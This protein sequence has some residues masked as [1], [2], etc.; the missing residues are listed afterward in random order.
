L[1]NEV[2]PPIPAATVVLVRDIGDH[3]E[4]LML[5][6][7]AEVS[8]G[9]LW[10]FPGGRV[11]VD[12]GDGERG[13]RHAA[14]REAAEEAGLVVDS[15]VLVPFAHWTPPPVALKRF[16]TWFFVAPAPAGVVSID[17]GEIH[18]HVWVTPSTAFERHAGGEIQLAPPTWVTLHWLAESPN[19]D[20]AMQRARAETVEHFSTHIAKGEDGELVA[21]WHGDVA[22]E[23][24]DLAAAGGRHRLAMIEGGWRYERFTAGAPPAGSPTY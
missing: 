24:G 11:E 10:V 21:L 18:E 12:D 3:L 16:A 15:E 23:G 19:V 13:A 1:T 14:A 7:N 5:R 20:A 9:G 17:G 6:R 22:Y 4:T 2:P 8:F